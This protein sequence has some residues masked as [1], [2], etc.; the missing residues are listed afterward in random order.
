MEAKDK[1]ESI[2]TRD[3]S[4][5]GGPLLENKRMEQIA[6]KPK[7]S[8]FF[9]NL[10]ILLWKNF[11]VFRRKTSSLVAILLCPTVC[12]LLVVY[13]QSTM[14]KY[15]REVIVDF[16]EAQISSSLPKC[17]PGRNKDNCI[18]LSTFLLVK[19]EIPTLYSFQAGK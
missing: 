3:G 5:L 15:T 18:S 13:F 16:P 10:L 17:F 2:F 14:N 12:C 9:S 1:S 11:L 8:M 19:T 6:Q 4:I 7:G